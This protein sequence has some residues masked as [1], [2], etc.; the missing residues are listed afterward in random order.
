MNLDMSRFHDVFFEEVAEHLESLERILLELDVANPSRDDLDAI[1]RAAHSIKG[2]SGTFG[3]SEMAAF[4]HHLESLLDKARNGEIQLTDSLVDLTLRAGDVLRGQLQHYRENAPFDPARAAALVTELQA[5][6]D[7]GDDAAAQPA[8]PRAPQAEPPAVRMS[9]A[10]TCGQSEAERASVREGVRSALESIG[11]LEAVAD[12]VALPTWTYELHTTRDEAMVRDLFEFVQTAADELTIGVAPAAQLA[13]PPELD[14]PEAKFG[15]F[16]DD[17]APEPENTSFGFF[18]DAPG[19]PD[20]AAHAAETPAAGP[21]VAGPRAA[22]GRSKSNDSGTIRVNLDK[23]D[24]LINLVGEMVI[25]QAMLTQAA[26]KQDGASEEMRAAIDQIA[27]HTR[28]LREGVMSI[29]MVPMSFI[30]SRFPRMVRDQA[31]GLG[32]KVTL[33]TIGDDTELDKGLIENIVDPLTHLVRNSLDHGIEPPDE[34]IAAGKDPCGTI[35]MRSS[36]QGGNVVIEIMDDGRG[37]SRE[38]ILAKALSKGLA[39]SADMPNEEVWSLIFMPGFSTAEKV[40]DLS[41]RGVGMDVV[42][43]NITGMGGRV[44]VASNA[45]HGTHITIRL[46]LTLAILD[47]LSVSVGRDI[48]IIPLAYIVES[49]QPDIGTVKPIPGRGSVL[50]FRDEFIPVIAMHELF[51][52]ERRSQTYADGIFVIVENEGYKAALFVDSLEAQHQVVIKS[53]ETNFRRVE[54]IAGATSLGDGRVSLILDVAGLL[55]LSGVV[56]AVA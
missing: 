53:I 22:A 14:L 51:A 26:A 47:G 52:L 33:Q 32:K 2:G 34:R 24:A 42:K 30:F 21:T 44:E 6:L 45:G 54:G 23:V 13:S 46:P 36:H 19:F 10:Y 31:A 56:G 43:R 55:R 37:L 48:F 12:D 4:T 1:F 50:H 38:K 18:D 20:P 15:F 27:Q 35:T 3:F 25:S 9:I 5:A 29:R 41:G 11:A 39:V 7:R 16:D 40:T 8:I 17:F 49:M 28:L